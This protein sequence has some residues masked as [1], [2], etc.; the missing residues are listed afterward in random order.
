MRILL[1]IVILALLFV[2]PVERLDIA[3]L[4]PVQT[5]AIH[6][7]D[8]EVVLRTDTKDEGRAKTLS[9][10]VRDLEEN[11]PGVIYLDTAEYL[12]ITEEAESLTWELERYLRPSVKVSFWDGEGNVEKAAKFLGIRRDLPTLKQWNGSRKKTAEKS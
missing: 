1:Y 10:A 5:V 6:I 3:K 8:G 7:A 4:Q 12:L 9:D 2:A 11:T